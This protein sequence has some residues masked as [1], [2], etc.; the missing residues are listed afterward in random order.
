VKKHVCARQRVCINYNE[1]LFDNFSRVQYV[2]KVIIS[3]A[4]RRGKREECVIRK[5]RM[6]VFT[7]NSKTHVI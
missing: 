4:H 2:S 6:R 1:E 3:F 7:R 5:E